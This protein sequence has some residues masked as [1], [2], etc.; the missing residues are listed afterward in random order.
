MTNPE[1]DFAGWATKYGIECSDGRTIKHGAFALNDGD[2]LPLVWQHGH[3][4]PGNVLGNVT[5]EHRDEGVYAYGL[6]NKTGQADTTRELLKHGDVNALS[7]YA[8]NL[9]QRGNTVVHGQLREVSIVLKGANPGALIDNIALQHADGSFTESESEAVIYGEPTEFLM[10][11]SD[12]DDSETVIDVIDSMNEKQKEVLFH[13]LGAAV[14]AAKSDDTNTST[15]VAQSAT[16]GE[17]DMANVFEKAA[18]KT[19]PAELMHADMDQVI[20][21]AIHS[22]GKL[23]D[24]VLAHADT[25]GIKDISVLFPDAQVLKQ[26][27]DFIKRDTGWVSPFLGAIH[28]SP[29]SRIKCV[30]ADI[31][32]DEARARGYITGTQKKDEVFKLLKRVITPQTI[33]KKQKFDRDDLIDIKW[34]I[35][36][37]VRQEMRLMIEEELA[38]AVLIGDGR[39][40]LSPDKIKDDNIKAVWTDAD[41]YSHKVLVSTATNDLSLVE[42]MIRARKHYKG[43]GTPTLYTTADVLTDLLLIKDK[44]DR[45]VFESEQSLAA[46]LRVSSIVTVEVMEGASRQVEAA[47]RNLVGIMLNPTDYTLG[48]DQGG[49]LT[50]F[51][52]FDIDFNQHKYLLETRV[53]GMLTVPKSALV[54]ER[55][56]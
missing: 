52:D 39:D 54:F 29:F 27:P 15:D 49:Q 55:A 31:T 51:D 41:L 42:A 7:I 56:A 50:S 17:A 37:W 21:S 14:E 45:Y 13:M 47:T 30:H 32:E 20:Q 19:Q 33:Y 23:K 26:Q 6:F 44:M 12:D 25:Y 10:H 4:D 40:I 8:T 11:E 24:A 38:R 34:D 22:G 3:N 9:D 43:T 46:R 18:D 48:A 16:E 28:K 2:T 53:S 36:P 5:L 1:Y 35:I